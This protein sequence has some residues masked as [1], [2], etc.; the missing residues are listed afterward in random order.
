MNYKNAGK[1]HK[2]PQRNDELGCP[3]WWEVVQTNIQTGEERVHKACGK[4]QDM[5]PM[6]L[7]EVIKAANRPAA[8]IGSMKETMAEKIEMLAH[9]AYRLANGDKQGLIK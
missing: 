5:L 7:T 3:W 4:S 1:C 6:M 8:E 9:Q 2:C